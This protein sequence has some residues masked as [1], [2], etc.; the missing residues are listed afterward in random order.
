MLVAISYDKISQLKHSPPCMPATSRDPASVRENICLKTIVCWFWSWLTFVPGNGKAYTE[1][2]PKANFTESEMR[3]LLEVGFEHVIILFCFCSQ[4]QSSHH[5]P[6]KEWDLE[7]LFYDVR[8]KWRSCVLALQFTWSGS[9]RP[10][11]DRRLV[12]IVSIFCRKLIQYDVGIRVFPLWQEVILVVTG[13]F[14]YNLPLMP[15]VI[16]GVG[17]IM[18]RSVA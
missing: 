6:T 5:Q 2:S 18:R 15:T 4:L 1:K 12:L 14:S 17:I 16:W 9:C 3:V 13:V 11:G 10:S 8:L 7:C